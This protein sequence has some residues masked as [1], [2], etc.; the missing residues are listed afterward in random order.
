M[1][2]SEPDLKNFWNLREGFGYLW[3][4]LTADSSK[5]DY[6]L[7]RKIAWKVF[8]AY[9]GWPLL[10]VCILEIFWHGFFHFVVGW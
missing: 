10:T 7:D 3:L 8:A 4:S 2:E 9:W 5:A 1:D 6:K